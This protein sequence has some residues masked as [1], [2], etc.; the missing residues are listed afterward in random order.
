ML[1]VFNK[2]LTMRQATAAIHKLAKKPYPAQKIWKRVHKH[3]KKSTTALMQASTLMAYLTSVKWNSPEY[4]WKG[5]SEAF[6]RHFCDKIREYKDMNTPGIFS[7]EFKL[8]LLQE[9]ISTHPELKFI[10]QMDE[11][12]CANTGTSRTYDGFRKV[13]ISAAERCDWFSKNGSQI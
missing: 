4:R 13:L 10:Q 8:N 7:N 5:G 2:K 11:L 6:I 9:T 12:L 1:S 3:N